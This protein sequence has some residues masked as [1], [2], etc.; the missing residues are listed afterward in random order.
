MFSALSATKEAIMRANRRDELFQ[1]VCDAAMACA[2]FTSA[3]IGFADAGSDFL[4]IVAA[5]GPNVDDAKNLHLANTAELPK[6]MAG[7]EYRTNSFAIPTICAR[8]SGQ[9]IGTIAQFL[10]DL[11]PAYPYCEMEMRLASCSS[12]GAKRM[13]LPR[14]S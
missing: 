3:T 11:E 5:S 10:S 14:N 13:F 9:N 2:K 7:T 6:G 4:R 8:T 12:C 1:L